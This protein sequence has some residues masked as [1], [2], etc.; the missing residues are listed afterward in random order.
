ML[1]FWL[2]LAKIPL[3]FYPISA[4]MR[5]LMRK[6]KKFYNLVMLPYSSG[7]LHI[8]HWYNIALA[9]IYSRFKKMQGNQIFA[10]MGFDSF[11]L[12]AE[13]AA[14][15][16]N[17]NPQQ[18]TEDNIAHMRKQLKAMNTIYD[19]SGQVVTSR[20]DY[21]KWTQWLF[22]QFYKNGLAYRADTLANWCPSCQTVLANEQVV[23][24]K[25]ERCESE[26]VQKKIKQWMLRITK[27]ADELISGLDN[28]DWPEQ[29]KTSQKNW[30]GKSE[31]ATIN[32]GIKDSELGIK[33]F[34]T[35][36]DTLFGATY[37][38]LAP[39]HELVQQ[40]KNKIENWGE[41]EQ[42]IIATQQKTEIERTDL[43]KE[44]TGVELKGIKAINP[45]NQEEISVFIA[46]YVLLGYGSGAIMAVPAHDQRDWEFA[47]KYDLPIREVIRGSAEIDVQKQVYSGQG[48][49]VNS[50]Q[51]DGLDYQEG[52]KK[53]T[54]V[55]KK[56][57]QG[58]F[59]VNYKMRDWIVSRQRYWGAPIPI[60]YCDKCGEVADE[61]LP[62]ELPD[63]VDI[64]PTG[65]SPLASSKKFVEVKCPQCGGPAR[66]ETD[67]LDTFVCS[68]WYF[69]RYV[70]PKNDQEFADQKKIE[71][72]LPVDMYIGGA[73]HTVM[74]LLY[75]RFFCKALLDLGLLPKKT[76]KEREPFLKLRH[77][78]IILGPDKQKMSKSRGNVVDPDALVQKYGAD[79]I[80]MHLCFMGPYEQGGPWDPK[81][82]TGIVRFL[83]RVKRVGECIVEL[84][85]KNELMVRS[86]PSISI[87]KAIKKIGKDVENLK[88]NTA[89]SELMIFFDGKNSQPDWRSKLDRNGELE[90][91]E[92]DI[93]ALTKFLIILAPFAP[94]TTEKLWK[95]LGNKN[96]VHDQTWPEFDLKLV[97]EEE[98]ELV[99]Q[100]NGKVR[101]RIMVSADIAEEEAKDIALGSAKVQK[102]IK[103]PQ[104]IIFVPGKLINLVG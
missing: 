17:V 18:W 36:A 13:N 46:D 56:N 39:E 69:Y 10:P 8:G 85:E 59:A 51:F 30:I 62:V 79:V 37:M 28:I 99:I 35:R 16:N 4:K 55:L 66:R 65:Q 23:F 81:G 9:D 24:G 74:H 33:V 68:A 96:S 58:D 61:K 101:D 25:C 88:F 41:V 89:I 87:H 100:V 90:N 98:I 20:P 67:T 14:I 12:P 21:Y 49:M 40:L 44:K 83:D 34:T 103:E 5:L 102:F 97:I 1:I 52:A 48:K 70:D 92:V 71:K 77:Q 95:K 26:V 86:K 7:N 60:I 76:F 38:V 45:I 104:K 84:I 72:L 6:N 27:Y 43:T 29:T 31:G 57:N 19:F 32:F 42:Y 75:A 64:K 80:R 73:E 53:I 11:G 91:K 47:K 22:L 63:D 3:S 94:E 78:G 54:E 93:E 15:K 2:N 82:L 50:G